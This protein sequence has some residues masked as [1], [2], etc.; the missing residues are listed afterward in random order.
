MKKKRDHL[1]DYKNQNRQ[2]VF[3]AI[4]E[5]KQISRTN[6][7]KRT[8]LSPASVSLIV[9]ELIKQKYIKELGTSISTG[10][11]AQKLLGVNE[12][13][14]HNIT[15]YINDG[16][17]IA[18]IVSAYLEVEDVISLEIK[19][20]SNEDLLLMIAEII[21]NWKHNYHIFSVSIGVD[22]PNEFKNTRVSIST[23]ISTDFI[24]IN[25]ALKF[26]LGVPFV[27]ERSVNFAALGEAHTSTRKERVYYL[28]L[29]KKIQLG[30]YPFISEEN[31][32]HMKIENDGRICSCG[33]VGCL[34]T[35]VS[36]QS[37]IE[38][39]RENLDEQDINWH[40]ISEAYSKGN[41][42]VTRILENVSK[43]LGKGIVNI[44]TLL[45]PSI[46]IIGGEVSSLNNK[47]E[48]GVIN[49]VKNFG[50]Y[51][52]ENMKV[53]LSKMGKNSFLIGGAKTYLLN[54][55]RLGLD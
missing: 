1:D 39:L 24:T 44:S 19:D 14:G 46:F 54:V 34:N 12:E 22:S 10:G 18:G 29:D 30:G 50:Y 49:S 36:S 55:F 37:I 20:I 32:A 11:R 33:K 17:L 38:H 7:A 48:E 6:I 41:K 40:F 15:L 43:Y 35:F 45:N 47:F 13:L 26:L 16:F 8:S 2:K 23:S 28:N 25:E 5:A 42:N 4:L 52:L 51:Q 21:N 3:N 53:S 31:V 27:I 9:D